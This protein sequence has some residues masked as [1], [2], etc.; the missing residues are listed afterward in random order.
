MKKYLFYILLIWPGIHI[1]AQ[2]GLDCPQPV[3]GLQ[4][5]NKI[6]VDHI[7]DNFTDDVWIGPTLLVDRPVFFIHG[8]GGQGDEDGT[9]GISWSQASLWSELNYMINSR[10][11]DYADV[12]L[13]FAAAELKGDLETYGDG[14]MDAFLIA[15]SQGGIVSRQIDYYYYTGELGPEPRTFGG[16]VTFGSPHHG[17]MILNNRDAMMSWAGDMCNAM[18]SGP[19]IEYVESNFWLD[20]LL[21]DYITQDGFEDIICNTFENN[22][23][24]FL[25]KDYFSGITESYMVGSEELE[26]LNDFT[27]EIP[28]VCFYGEETEPLI[29]NTLVHAL[30][31]HEPNNALTYGME[32][33]GATDDPTLAEYM[34][35]LTGR[36][37]LKYLAYDYLADVYYDLYTGFDAATLFCWLFPL[38]GV[39]AA[40]SYDE[41]S[42]ISAAYKEGYDWCIQANANW[43]GFI[44][45]SEWV[46][47]VPTCHCMDWGPLGDLDEEFYPASPDGTCAT[48]DENTN[49]WL[50]NN[51]VLLEKP[52][53]GV[54]L[55]ESASECLG[56]IPVIP[57]YDR[58][59][60][61]SNHFSMRNDANTELKLIELYAGHHGD[62]F[63]TAPR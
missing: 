20:L 14:S 24:P 21:N 27:P 15:H 43:K 45:A 52:S 37:A 36:Y 18:I 38:C 57:P 2:T 28:Y 35:D 63:Y 1:Y 9:V 17:A 13:S 7:P 54:V 46:E 4:I 5:I 25:F 34:D 50:E 47:D 23:A 22:L 62:Y 16:L 11:P 51:F 56:Q 31:G 41:C 8:L 60:E 32:P 58:K 26:T 49:C 6:P 40:D 42:A 33:F 55:V 44:G 61:G 30:P 59:M 48:E 53:D 10:R 12:S 39:E 19:V 29:W 3:N